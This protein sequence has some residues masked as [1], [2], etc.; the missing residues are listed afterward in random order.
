MNASDTCEIKSFIDFKS[1]I[2]SLQKQKM[3]TFNSLVLN[4]D[5]PKVFE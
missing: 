1:L 5:N 2:A 4:V 3:S